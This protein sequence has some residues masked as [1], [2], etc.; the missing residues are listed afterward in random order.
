MATGFEADADAA[1][2]FFADG[3]EKIERLP[4][5][6]SR[7]AD[8]QQRAQAVHAEMRATRVAFL[9]RHAGEL[10]E[11]LTDGREK[12]VRVEDLIYGPADLVPGLVPTRTQIAQEREHPQ[13]DKEG[14]EVDQGLFLSYVLSDPIAGAHLVHAM[15]R[16]RRESLELSGE[17]QLKGRVEIGATT[18]ERRDGVGYLWHGNPRFLNAEDDSTTST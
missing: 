13:K 15:L 8:E 5:R 16:P 3:L 2:E 14:W 18:V 1:S 10:Y 12:F 6:P 9:R 4:P 17:F 7:S 11:R